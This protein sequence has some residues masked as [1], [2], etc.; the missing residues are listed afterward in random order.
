MG[1]GS[2]ID[3][4]SLVEQLVAAEAQPAVTRLAKQES[5]YQAQL[6]ALGSLKGA[7]SSFK[8]A[9]SG[10]TSVSSFD[11]RSATSSNA[12]VLTVTAGSKAVPGSYELEVLQLAKAQSLRSQAF[13]SGS[14]FVGTGTLTFHFGDAG[15]AAQT[16]TINPGNGSLEGIRDAVNAAKIG[17]QASI[18]HAENKSYLVFSS[19]KTGT[20][21]SIA[22]ITVSEGL[23]ALAY[24]N[25]EEK[26]AAQD[27]EVTINGITVKSATNTVTGALDGVTLNLVKEGSTTLTIGFDKD[28]VT[29][30]VEGFVSA[31]NSLYGTIKSLSGYDAEKKTGGVLIGDSTVRSIA[32]QIRNVLSSTV[33]GLTGSYRALADIGIKTQADGTLTIDKTKLNKALNENFEDI[34]RLFAAAGK[35]SD[36]L[37]HFDSATAKTQ[38]GEYDVVITRL[39]S[40]GT[41]TDAASSVSST[42]VDDSNDT[43]TIKVDGVTSGTISLTHKDYG[44]GDALAAELQSRINGDSALQKAGVSVTVKYDADTQRF[45]FTSNRVGAGSS[46]EILSVKDAEASGSIGLTVNTAAKTDGQDVAGRIG[47]QEAVGNG[48]YLTGTGK[49]E[50]LKLE[51]QGDTLG[52]RGTVM[53]SRGVADKLN[54]LLSEWLSTDSF[55]NQ[56]TESLNNSIKD[57]DKQRDALELR[58]ESLQ[59]RYMAQFTAMDTLIAQLNSTSNFLTQRLSAL[60]SSNNK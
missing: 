4:K 46:V 1:I 21:N 28:A 22:N 35:P 12:E 43:F 13:D 19:E 55:L 8:T 40:A 14:A 38:E 20:A 11:K 49:A 23:S 41:Y 37:V 26:V 9:L 39:A 16:V 24:E 3:V 45:T 36:T 5:K 47:G 33:P 58:L 60:N 42:V 31:Y 17:V 32:S 48:R 7:L 56:R 34:G 44:S 6:S 29:K 57:I 27:A 18:V 51:I 59:K 30:A 10:L 53:F 2:G 15:K 50:G 25:F 52:E 54:T